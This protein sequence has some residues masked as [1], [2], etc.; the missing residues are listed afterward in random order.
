[1]NHVLIDTMLIGIAHARYHVMC[2]TYVKFEYIFQFLTPTLPI[3]YM[4]LSL[5]SDEE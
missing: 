3:H 1:M 4:P 2:T 5:G